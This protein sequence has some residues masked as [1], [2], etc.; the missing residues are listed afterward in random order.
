MRPFLNVKHVARPRKTGNPTVKRLQQLLGTRVYEVD[1]RSPKPR[2]ISGV[3][4]GIRIQGQTYHHKLKR[5]EIRSHEEGIMEHYFFLVD[6]C[7]HVDHKDYCG[8]PQLTQEWSEYC[9][10][11]PEYTWRAAAKRLKDMGL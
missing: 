7:I 11:D 10:T 2:I 5:G 3:V 9:A 6:V 8:A 1:W 4:K